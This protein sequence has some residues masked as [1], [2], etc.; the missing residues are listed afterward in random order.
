MTH[1]RTYRIDSAWRGP[2]MAGRTDWIHE[3]SNA[4]IGELEIAADAV[5]A[6]DILD[7]FADDFDLPQLD[8]FLAKVRTD[9]VDGRGFVLLRGLP[10]DRW[11]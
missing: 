3:F 2:D 10:V 7:L 4:E 6:Q 11:P 9:V 5:I 1:L 8:P